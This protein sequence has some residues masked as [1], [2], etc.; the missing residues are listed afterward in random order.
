M[1]VVR[2]IVL[3][4]QAY[5]DKGLRI[6]V[7]TH[8]QG[9]E[10]IFLK[11]GVRKGTSSGYW[12]LGAIVRCER[13]SNRGKSSLRAVEVEL[14]MKRASSDLDVFHHLSYVLEIGRALGR[15]HALAAEA[16]ELFTAYLAFLETSGADMYRLFTWQLALFGA[17]GMS[18]TP[19][20]CQLTGEVPN[21]FSIE[22]GGAVR[23]QDC[24]TAIPVETSA[25][26][27]LARAWEMDY[28][29]SSSAHIPPLTT[30]MQRLWTGLLGYPLKSASF[31][32]NVGRG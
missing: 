27:S 16:F 10:T 12:S 29:S 11:H 23:T 17:L 15:D 19:W 31:L 4:R 14:M 2:A 1:S 13:K 30:L 25:L 28:E 8:D 18:L 22:H 24:P 5:G 7:L 3:G 6:S 32:N 9:V 26:R 21:G 20:P